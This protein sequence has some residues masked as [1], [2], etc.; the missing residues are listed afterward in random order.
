GR[1]HDVVG[2]GLLG[3][4]VVH[5]VES[6]RHV[7]EAHALLVGHPHRAVGD[8]Q[9]RQAV[10]RRDLVDLLLDRAGIAVDQNP[11]GASVPPTTV[12]SGASPSPICASA[13]RPSRPYGLPSVSTISKWLYPSPTSNVAD[14]PAACT[15]RQK[16]IDWR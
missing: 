6:A 14:L 3:D 16:S 5:R 9:H 2:G 4:P 13:A 10:A 15:A 12:W 7:L 1:R 8:D 11:H